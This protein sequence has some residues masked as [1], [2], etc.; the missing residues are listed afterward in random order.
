MT[1]P[2]G[3]YLTRTFAAPPTAVFDAWVTPASFATWWGGSEVIV[4]LDS[5]SM[6]VRPG[7]TW[8][9]TL[10]VG[11]GMP[12][13]HFRGEYLEVDRPNKLV[14]TLT[15]EPG[16]EREVLTVILTAVDGGTEMQFSQT[17]GH[18]TPEQYAGTA[19]GWGVALMALDALLA[20]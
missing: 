6:D 3:A 8:K 18:L 10:I 5:V 9:A 15:D 4:P 2:I 11:N 19:D 13:F 7:G 12:E 16:D 14:M 20:A 1:E 17:G